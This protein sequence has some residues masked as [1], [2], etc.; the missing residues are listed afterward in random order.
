MS[1]SPPPGT[2]D[3][4]LVLWG[5]TGYTGRLVAR[6]LA[7]RAPEGVRWALGGRDRA[8]LEELRGTLGADAEIVVADAQDEAS[9][10]ALAR[11]TRVV[12]ATV[13]PFARHG[14]PLVAACA[15]AGT[16]YADVTAEAL[17]MRDSIDAFHA[18]A[19]ETGARVV[20]ACGFDSL[21]SDLG[22][23]RLQREALAQRGRP[24]T[25]VT[26]VVGPMSGG[27]SGGT[28][29][30]SLGMIGEM[31]R[32]PSVRRRM[33]DPDLLAPGAPPSQAAPS[34][35]W[36]QHVP[37]LN[38]WTA[39]FP[40]ALVNAKVVRR[41][42]ALLGEPWGEEVR[43]RERMRA[44]TWARA[45]TTGMA[46][47]VVPALLA[48]GPLRRLAQRLAPEPGEG[49]GEEARARGFFRSAF[50]GSAPDDPAPLV[51]HVE[52]DLD[53]GYGMTARMLSE[54]GLG[55]AQGEF[56]GEGGVLTPAFVGG[57]RLV[58]RLEGA[59]IRFRAEH[60][61]AGAPS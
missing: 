39:P 60:G 38:A 8:R 31:A 48:L 14:T 1:V 49:P 35:W 28:V 53:P 23:W 10:A 20:H 26:H 12:L 46:L 21:P 2:R 52:A 22:A 36:P 33:A 56:E 16:D 7:D 37:T 40:M 6:N 59:G 11:R 17:W 29:A 25:E 19:R 41:T 27:V 58:E 34:P 45:A 54:V 18:L 9:L 51:L 47:G 57:M 50:V 44:A 13:G 30:T 3:L 15:E 32:D 55:L 24:R 42:R 4:D 43:Y 61:T 5:A